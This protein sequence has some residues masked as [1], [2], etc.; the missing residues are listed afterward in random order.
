MLTGAVTLNGLSYLFSADGSLYTG[1]FND[2]V[3]A[4][5]YETDGHMVTGLTTING[6]VY[7]FDSLGN[8][9]TGT[10][11]IGGVPYFFDIDGKMITDPAALLPPDTTN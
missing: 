9:Q 10:I 5:Y 2:G 8:M 4:K 11:D 6:Y 3:T 7:Y 1:W